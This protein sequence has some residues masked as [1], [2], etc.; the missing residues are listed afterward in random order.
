D[1]SV[2]PNDLVAPLPG[3]PDLVWQREDAVR[4][5]E[6]E[7]YAPVGLKGAAELN[8]FPSGQPFSFEAQRPALAARGLSEAENELAAFVRARRRPRRPRSAV[9]R[10]PAHG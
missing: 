1:R 3:P 6:E 2:V 7:G 10:R 8:P 4:V 9:I 5:W